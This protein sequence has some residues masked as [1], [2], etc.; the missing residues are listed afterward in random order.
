MAPNTVVEG[1]GEIKTPSGLR[2][3]IFPTILLVWTYTE[4]DE[5]FTKFSY[6]IKYNFLKANI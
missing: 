6:N 3:G 1:T 5:G 4:F 2:Q